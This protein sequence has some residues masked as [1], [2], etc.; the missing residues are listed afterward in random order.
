MRRMQETADDDAEHR[1]ATR[2]DQTGNAYPKSVQGGLVEGVSMS[3]TTHIQSAEFH[4]SARSLAVKATVSLTPSGLLAI[5]AL[6][7]GIL[8]STA[9]LVAVA[10]R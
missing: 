5:A 3:A 7:S 9:V 1:P 8:L 2:C 4:I 10:K 6:V